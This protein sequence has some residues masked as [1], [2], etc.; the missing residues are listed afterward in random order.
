MKSSMSR[1][2]SPVA[3]VAEAGGYLYHRGGLVHPCPDALGHRRYTLVL[4]EGR[5]L[6][7]VDGRSAD[8][9]YPRPRYDI[10]AA[11]HLH[12]S[13]MGRATSAKHFP[14][15]PWTARVSVATACRWGQQAW[16][17]SRT[18]RHG[19]PSGPESRHR[20]PLNSRS[21]ASQAGCGI[22]SNQTTRR[23]KRC[24]LLRGSRGC[25]DTSRST[26]AQSTSRSFPRLLARLRS[27]L[28]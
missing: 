22:P 13:V 21:A 20:H 24:G 8:Q 23:T 14:S 5:H 3:H 11:D 18:G 25:S 27:L 9:V 4:Q 7:P 16:M 12:P 1:R 26:T 28:N 15:D 19:Y 2:P 17:V 6:L 10:H